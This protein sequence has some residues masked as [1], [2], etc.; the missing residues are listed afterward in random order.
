[1]VTDIFGGC[2][3]ETDGGEKR[4]V[5]SLESALVHWIGAP[6]GPTWLFRDT[7]IVR[8]RTRHRYG[9]LFRVWITQYHN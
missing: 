2:S 3:G 6:F 7:A 9:E 5:P 8:R 4:S 1:M